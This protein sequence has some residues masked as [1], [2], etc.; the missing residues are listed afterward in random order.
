MERL[1]TEAV[2]GGTPKELVRAA[3]MRT[4]MAARRRRAAGQDDDTIRR[5]ILARF[6]EVIEGEEFG[7]YA[8]ETVMAAA[9]RTIEEV[10]RGGPAPRPDR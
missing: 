10:L 3:E 4:R 7:A 5:E 8:D 9:R 6:R 2:A 1:H